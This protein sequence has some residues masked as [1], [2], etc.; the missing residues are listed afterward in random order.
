MSVHVAQHS[1]EEVTVKPETEWTIMVFFAGDPHL[2]PSMTSQLKALKDAGFEANT[3]VLVHYDPNER[4]S[5]TTTFEINRMRKQQMR[6]LNLNPTVIGDG[7]NPFVRNLVEDSIPGGPPKSA[8]ALNALKQFLQLGIQYPARH[9]M[10]FLVGHGMI[11]GN[12]AFLPDDQPNSA[13][14]LKDLGETLRAFS[15]MVTGTV[16]LIGLHSC[17]MSAL[18]VFYELKGAARY[19]MATEGISFVSS[20]PY[21]QVLKKLLGTVDNANGTGVHVDTLIH[22][23][24]SLSLH[25]STDFMFSGLSADLA[26]CRLD[27]DEKTVGNL[28]AS[29][30]YLTR[31]LKD[32]LK[33]PRGKE[34]IQLAHLEAQ[35]Y[36]QETYTD[37]YDF[38]L[39]LARRCDHGDQ[40]Q[41]KMGEACNGVIGQL[42]ESPIKGGIIAQSDY[43]GPLYQYSHGLS[44]YFPWSRPF[45]DHAAPAGED[46]LSRYHDYKFTTELREDSW[47]SFLQE[48]FE[49]TQRKSRI[50]ES[51]PDKSQADHTRSGNGTRSSVRPDNFFNASVVVGDALRKASPALDETPRK[52]SPPLGV[53]SCVCTV[54]NYPMEFTWSPR[55]N[56]DPNKEI[57]AEQETK[58]R[59]YH[60]ATAEG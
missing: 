4:G 5:S 39:C 35:S 22:S 1:R 17:S 32:G 9:Y 20:W 58:S 52:A 49:A 47:L 25:N 24:Q 57:I 28:N 27:A 37:L 48:Y 60:P 19:M 38:C 43:F 34:L 12:D 10:I 31:A 33:D 40:T 16:E 56:E 23:I 15:T 54:K 2:S 53:G 51:Q 29:I 21:R 14:G 55:A 11:V 30:R 59:A 26:L 50:A 42:Q 41:K 13:I 7:R 18:E 8:N 44:V 46:I 3:N 45:H 6:D 36:W